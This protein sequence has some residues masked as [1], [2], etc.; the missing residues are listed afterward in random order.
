MTDNCCCTGWSAAMSSAVFGQWLI[1]GWHVISRQLCL[2]SGLCNNKLHSAIKLRTIVNSAKSVSM[3]AMTLQ[4]MQSNFPNKK[5]FWSEIS[6]LKIV[7]FQQ[8]CEFIV[9]VFLHCTPGMASPGEPRC[10]QAWLMATSFEV[11][12]RIAYVGPHRTGINKRS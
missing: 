10:T 3:F 7:Y 2:S 1:M 5:L 12:T 11:P 8:N 6:I 4:Y 9:G